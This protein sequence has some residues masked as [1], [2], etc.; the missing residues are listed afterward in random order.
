VAVKERGSD[1]VFLRRI[2]PGGADKS[3]GI[4][5]AQ[6]AG[7][8]QKVIKRAQELLVELEQNHVQSQDLSLSVAQSAAATTPISLFT[9]STV[10]ELLAI[11]IT[12]I[13]PIEAINILYQLQNQAK[14]ESGKL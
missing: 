10:D 2:I 5:V 11:D 4:H 13:T 8:P 9:S 6:L 1:V 3:Y 14:Q 7:L 12:T